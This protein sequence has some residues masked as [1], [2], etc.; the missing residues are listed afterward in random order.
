MLPET[1]YLRLSQ[2]IGDRKKGIPALIPMAESTWFLGVKTG[3]Y[4]KAV[5]LGPRMRGYRV[6]EIKKLMAEMGN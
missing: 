4:P 2:I 6:E 1:G 5:S 3:R